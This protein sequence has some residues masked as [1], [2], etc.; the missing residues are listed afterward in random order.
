MNVWREQEL[1]FSVLNFRHYHPAEHRLF[2]PMCDWL[3]EAQ[4]CIFSESEGFAVRSLKRLCMFA[5]RLL[6]K[7][8]PLPLAWVDFLS[9]ILQ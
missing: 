2:W 7:P 4:N 9:W 1:F 6:E 8:R 5:A 3:R